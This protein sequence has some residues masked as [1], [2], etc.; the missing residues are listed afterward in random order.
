MRPYL[1]NNEIKLDEAITL[2]RDCEAILIPQG[3]AIHLSAGSV[4]FVTQALGTSVTVNINGNLARIEG[5]DLDALGFESIEGQQN[6]EMTG[7]GTVKES[8]LW[9]Q[10]SSCFDPE[11][12]VSIVEL[13]LIYSCDV[14]PLKE[15][16][17]IIGNRVT[18]DMTLTAAGCGMGDILVGD[19]KSKL[20]M[21]ANVTEVQVELVFDPP[22]NQTMMSEAA[23]LQMGM[24]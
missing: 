3:T 24:F 20:E 8:E 22:W 21:V 18:V 5:R 19:V 4:V 2:E 11:I 9:E 23:R 12:P 17:K 6:T 7:D 16:E 14:E 15:D 1:Q 13:G 10:M